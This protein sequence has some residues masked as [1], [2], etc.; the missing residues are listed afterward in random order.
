MD[1][2]D[3]IDASRLK[4]LTGDQ[5]KALSEKQ[6]ATFLL[7]C[8]QAEEKH[9]HFLGGTDIFEYHNFLE[10]PLGTAWLGGNLDGIINKGNGVTYASLS[11]KDIPTDL[12]KKYDNALAILTKANLIES[13]PEQSGRFVRLTGNGQKEKI[14]SNFILRRFEIPK[15]DRKKYDTSTEQYTEIEFI[16]QGGNGKVY[17]VIDSKKRTWALKVLDPKRLRGP[18]KLDRLRNEIALCRGEV[19]EN[20]IRICDEGFRYLEKEKVKQPFYVM[21]IYSETLRRVMLSETSLRDRLKIFLKV[22]DGM[23]AIH[24]MGV[25]HRD[26]K[27]ENI[28]T[29]SKGE[30]VVVAD[31]GIAH[32]AKEV[33]VVLVK[34]IQG[35]KLGNFRYSAPEQR[36]PEA[37]VDH[38]ADIFSLGLILNELFTGEVIQGT[39]FKKIQDVSNSHA[40]LDEIVEKMANQNPSRRPKR[41]AEIKDYILKG[42]R[43]KR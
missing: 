26:L 23:E 41:I 14:S 40:Y 25:F 28:L 7:A 37:V 24:N 8:F 15:L 3:Q 20:I 16:G 32:I 35:V 9:P 18:E 10:I 5:L 39:G 38:L 36:N 43:K 4:N 21:K 33:G 29:N 30:E 17:K 2:G 6:F 1:D 27:P 19:H 22:L 34:T 42:T 11:I 13:D 31:F 12:K